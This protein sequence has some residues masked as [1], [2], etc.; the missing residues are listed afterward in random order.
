MANRASCRDC[1]ND[2]ASESTRAARDDD[3]TPF[4]IHFH[5][6]THGRG[7]SQACQTNDG[8]A[9]AANGFWIYRISGLTTPRATV[10]SVALRVVS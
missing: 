8:S 7:I 6:Q 9:T 2:D 10:A 4:Q 3:V 1:V 5:A